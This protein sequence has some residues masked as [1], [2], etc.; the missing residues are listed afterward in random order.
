M[1]QAE[2]AKEKVR[3]Y[4][5]RVD[6]GKT[7]A[8]YGRHRAGYPEELYDR[9]A[10]FGVGR[11]GQRL[12]DLAT[13]T[14][15]LGRGFARRGCDVV[16]LDI[17]MAL[18]L[19]G[20][21][22]D[23]EAGL[24]MRYARG[25]A[26]ALP[27]RDRSFDVVSAGQSWHWFDRRIAASEVHRVLRP[28]GLI[29]IAHFDW[30]ALPGNVVEATEHLI[31]KH[32]PKWALGGGLGIH[33]MWPRDLA[34]AGFTDIETFS[35]DV[36]APYTHEGWRGRIRASAGVGGTLGPQQVMAFDDD[37][38]A[39]LR[40]KYPDDPMGVHHRTFAAVGRSQA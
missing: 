15:F 8:D 19:E 23:A 30:I 34:I 16:G 20:R 10:L 14:G 12:L 1:N 2:N 27:V 26:E 17:S 36:M 21:H 3:D 35:F 18:M 4:G 40:D 38:A 25:K 24:A 28:D 39:L 29:V 11:E 33:P 5:R 7:A 22:L 13:G 37:L 31:V 6:F 9:L 32:N